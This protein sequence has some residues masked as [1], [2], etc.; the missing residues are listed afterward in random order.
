MGRK[1][2]IIDE[3][4][5]CYEVV[6][7]DWR[8]QLRVLLGLTLIG[9]VSAYSVLQ[10]VPAVD[11]K[12]WLLETEQG[13]LLSNLAERKND[14]AKLEQRLERMH[15]KEQRL[16]RSILD[17]QAID[18]GVWKGG[19]GGNASL[20]AINP[21]LVRDLHLMERALEHKLN[22][23]RKN[24]EAVLRRYEEKT[25]QLNS[26]P[27][28]KPVRGSVS[29]GFGYRCHPF[30]GGLHK[31]EGVDFPVPS[32]SPVVAAGNGVVEIAEN[33]WN[34]YGCQVVVRHDKGYKTRYAHLSR[35]NVRAGARV[36]RGQ[37]IGLSGNT[38]LSTGPHLHYEILKDGQPVNPISYLKLNDW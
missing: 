14:F 33:S 31:H 11:V 36:K 19:F 27:L 28:L 32:G 21:V 4:T 7:V 35:F 25:Y 5:L 26:F 10:A 20:F 15:E 18:E 22:V 1:T 30:H 6:G 12:A 23:K 17:L 37:V 2:Y 34:G 8:A 9:L 24:L 29:S 38:G 16:Y 3:E 13:F